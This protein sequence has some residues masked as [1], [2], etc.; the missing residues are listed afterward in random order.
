MQHC[1]GPPDE[2]DKQQPGVYDHDENDILSHV[3]EQF[4]PLGVGAG[5]PDRLELQRARPHRPRRPRRPQADAE[6]DHHRPGP[7]QREGAQERDGPDRGGALLR[8]RVEPQLEHLRRGPADL[9]GRRRCHAD[10]GVRARVDQDLEEDEVAARQALLLRLRLRLRSE[11]PGVA[12]RAARGR[13]LPVQVVRRQGHLRA[14][15]ERRAAVRLLEG[16]RGPLRAVPGLVGG[17][18]GDPGRPRGHPRHGARRGG[19]PAGVGARVRHPPRVQVA[20][21]AD[22]APRRGARPARGTARPSCCGA[23]VSR[24]CAATTAGAGACA[25][26][27]TATGSSRRR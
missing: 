26:R 14:P 16:R 21:E 24:R 20:T 18:A 12:A 9:Q 23:P 10:E 4:L 11:R 6:P 7:P 3:I 8:R 5:L 27:R 1:T 19:V 2:H 13:Q 15:A 25:A 22:H 17:R